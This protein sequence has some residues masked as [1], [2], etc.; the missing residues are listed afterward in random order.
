LAHR[1]T[2]KLGNQIIIA[3]PSKLK[4]MRIFLIID[5]EL[6]EQLLTGHLRQLHL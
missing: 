1:T 2:M 4:R 5:A 3:Q 6:V